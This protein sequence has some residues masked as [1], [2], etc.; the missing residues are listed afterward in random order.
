MLLLQD[1]PLDRLDHTHRGL[2]V[3]TQQY[4]AHEIKAVCFASAPAPTS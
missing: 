3:I 4:P 1:K 2:P